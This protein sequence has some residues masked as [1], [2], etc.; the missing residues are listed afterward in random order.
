[1][2]GTEYALLGVVFVSETDVILKMHCSMRIQI[3]YQ[4]Q[5]FSKQ[6]G[7]TKTGDKTAH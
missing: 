5:D 7:P 6:S 2:G 4:N 3:H 1:M